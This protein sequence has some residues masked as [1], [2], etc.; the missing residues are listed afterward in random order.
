MR[1]FIINKVTEENKGK[2]NVISYHGEKV[3]IWSADLNNY[4]YT[5]HFSQTSLSEGLELFAFMEE[6]D[7][8]KEERR[9]YYMNNKKQYGTLKW[10]E[11]E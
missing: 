3:R 10:E 9:Q 5:N 2:G 11:I 1:E 4:F 7:E 8:M 6:N